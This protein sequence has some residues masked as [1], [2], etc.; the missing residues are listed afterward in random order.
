MN[1]PLK[2]ERTTSGHCKLLLGFSRT[3]DDE[4]RRTQK[5]LNDKRKKNNSDVKNN[6]KRLKKLP[7]KLIFFLQ[8]LYVREP[9]LKT[10]TYVEV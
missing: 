3:V 4:K 2:D 5:C 10:F 8:H 6:E 7:P 1:G 9:S